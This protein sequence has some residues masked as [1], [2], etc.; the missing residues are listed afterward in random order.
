[1]KIL[2][3]G[4][5]SFFTSSLAHAQKELGHVVDVIGASNS[6]NIFYNHPPFEQVHDQIEDLLDR[7]YDIIHY[8]RG[9]SLYLAGASLRSFRDRGVGLF[10]SGYPSEFNLRLESNPPE[11]VLFDHLFLSSPDLL[12]LASPGKSFSYLSLPM[13]FKRIPAYQ[14]R[15]PNTGEMVVLHIPFATSGDESA[16]I[17]AQVEALQ[18]K[19]KFSFKVLRPEDLKTFNALSSA[20]SEAH[21]LVERLNGEAPG[22]LG[23]LALAHGMTVFSTLRENTK[24]QWSQLEHCPVLNVDS[25]SFEK[26][27]ALVLRE[28]KSLRDFGKRGRQFAEKNFT[29]STVAGLC[30]QSYRRILKQNEAPTA[31]NINTK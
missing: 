4:G 6:D 20:L 18:S 1:M 11:L 24:L 25:E 28:P 8:H 13:D 27:L 3:I 22:M 31:P 10:Y 26:R 23:S 15:E 7:K 19:L 16:Q 30:D 14:L 21:V 17:I 29:A 5:I 2:H 12:S 9:E